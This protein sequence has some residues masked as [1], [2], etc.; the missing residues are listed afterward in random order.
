MCELKLKKVKQQPEEV[1]VVINVLQEIHFYQMGH[2][3]IVV[4]HIDPTHTQFLGKCT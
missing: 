1:E 2:S 3:T 4:V